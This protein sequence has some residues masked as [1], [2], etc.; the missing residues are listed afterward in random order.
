MSRI[1]IFLIFSI[2]VILVSWRSLTRFKSH[3]FFRFF[4]WECILWL[5]ASN[6]KFWFHDPFS[7]N[8]IV[9]WI[10]L[11]IAGYLVIAGVILMH[12]FGK[13][14]KTRDEK[15]LFEFEKTTELVDSGIFQYIRHPLYASLVYLTWAVFLKNISVELLVV[16]FFSTVL[17]Y[18]TARY[19]EKECIAFFG[20]KY[21]EYMKKSKMFI[22]YIF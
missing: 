7:F 1:I 14:G 18:F 11:I 12:K 19:D 17:L 22:P 3:G 15:T 13:P 21:R 20:E 2:P 5:F 9:S 6:Y 16:A 8:Q 10:L 4:A